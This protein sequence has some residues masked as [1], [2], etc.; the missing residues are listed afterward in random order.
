MTQIQTIPKLGAPNFGNLFQ[1]TLKIAGTQFSSKD[2]PIQTI[3]TQRSHLYSS[4]FSKTIVIVANLIMPLTEI[5]N[6]S[7]D[8]N[9]ENNE[10]EI[11]GKTVHDADKA[12]KSLKEYEVKMLLK[13][14]VKVENDDIF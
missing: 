4:T 11:V 5:S 8:D 7:L 2:S 14:L 13:S 6:L 1:A 9:K 12:K 10:T 3:W